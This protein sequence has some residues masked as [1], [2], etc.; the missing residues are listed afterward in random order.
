MSISYL[1]SSLDR[2]RRCRPLFERTR[3]TASDGKLTRNLRLPSSQPDG[4]SRPRRK[5]EKS[6]RGAFGHLLSVG[7][8]SFLEHDETVKSI[9]LQARELA[10]R[11]AKLKLTAQAAE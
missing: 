9:K 3:R 8:A 11:L 10:P 5:G 1:V 6:L 7:Q 2:N 4:Y